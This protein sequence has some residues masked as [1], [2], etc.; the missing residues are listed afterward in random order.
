MQETRFLP[1]VGKIPWRR[2]WL[3][4]TVLLGFPTGSAVKNPLRRIARATGDMGSIPGLG[5]SPEEGH[6]NP[7]QYFGRENPMDRR[8]WRATVHKVAKS[9]TQLKQLS[10]HAHKPW[11]RQL[12]SSSLNASCL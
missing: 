3:P 10:T 1:W 6:G 5:R 4:T 12:T 2:E 9:W 8:A 7:L 11:A